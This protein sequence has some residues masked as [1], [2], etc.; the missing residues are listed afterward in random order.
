L[1][2]VVFFSFSKASGQYHSVKGTVTETIGNLTGSTAWQQ[3]GREEHAR[4]EGE[5][6]AALAKG[7]AEG[8]ADRIGGRVDNV[9]G[10]VTGDK[11]KQA[12]GEFCITIVWGCSLLI[13]SSSQ[14]QRGERRNQTECTPYDLKCINCIGQTSADVSSVVWRQW[15]LIP[16]FYGQCNTRACF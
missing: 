6:N 1:C 13:P 10:A 3:S 8:T 11:T 14:A 9:I 16:S 5:Y 2:I 7:Y 12:E 15:R 4:G